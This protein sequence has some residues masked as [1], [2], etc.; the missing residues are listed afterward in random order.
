MI[1]ALIH[2]NVPKATEFV[3]S[4]SGVLG[5]PWGKEFSEVLTVSMEY[6]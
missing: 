6:H 1:N 2:V 3:I 5:V 4:G